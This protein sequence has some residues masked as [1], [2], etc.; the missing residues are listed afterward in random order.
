M[1]TYMNAKKTVKLCSIGYGGNSM[2]YGAGCV[3]SWYAQSPEE[4]VEHYADELRPSVLLID[5]RPA[6]DVSTA[7]A[8]AS[9]MVSVDMAEGDVDR[10]GSR[11]TAEDSL[12]LGALKETGYGPVIQAA[13][14]ANEVA[15]DVPGPLDY[16]P[17]GEYV[18]W[19]T[20]RGALLYRYDGSAFQPVK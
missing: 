13:Q 17:I 10:F 1:T 15:P 5:K 2:E 4:I 12:M 11:Y 8:Y 20:S 3:G 18:E 9:P 6:L 14:I 16:I 7:Y 19:W